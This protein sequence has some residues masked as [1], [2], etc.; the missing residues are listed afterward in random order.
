MPSAAAT[1]A[2]APLAPR[3]E[4]ALLC[5]ALHREGYDDHFFG[6][7]TYRQP[8]DTLLVNPYVLAWDEITPDDVIRIDLDGSVL[9]G[10]EA[11]TPAVLLHLRFHAARPDTG[12]LVH[13]HPRYSTVWAA[14]GTMPPAYDQ[15]GAFV[16]DDECVVYDDYTG[17]VDQLDAVDRNVAAVG[18][19][20]YALLANHGVLV[21]AADVR[22]AHHRAVYLEHRSRL[23][24]QVHALDATRRPMPEAGARS[25]QGLL[26]G[27]GGSSPHLWEWAVRRELR[28]DPGLDVS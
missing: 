24:W 18:A 6:H 16:P 3:A 20:N 8:D 17:A 21:A 7:I 15:L 26:A 11:V 12:V 9:E 19:A 10:E 1:V 4:L 25:L 27:V 14:A 23:A 28:L 5:R 22:Q 2:V 13:H